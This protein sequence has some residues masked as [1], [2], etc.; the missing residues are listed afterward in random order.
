MGWI[1][2]II[3]VAVFLLLL[4]PS[5]R[6]IGPTQVGLVQKRFGFKELSDDNPVAFKHE[7]G[8]Q[9]DLL[10]PGLRLKFWITHKVERFP[11]VQVPAGEIGV[12]IAQVG[13]PRCR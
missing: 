5:L 3:V 1:I 2:A 4:L 12:V 8:Y 7:P 6:R 10:M 9:A 11:W 13:L